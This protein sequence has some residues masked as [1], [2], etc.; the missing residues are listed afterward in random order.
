MVELN[1]NWGILKQEETFDNYC[2]L[3][4]SLGAGRATRKTFDLPKKLLIPHPKYY[5]CKHSTC[6]L[7]TRVTLL[8]ENYARMTEIEEYEQI[9]KTYKYFAAKLTKFDSV[10]YVPW[11]NDRETQT[12]GGIVVSSSESDRDAENED[13]VAPLDEDA[14]NSGTLY[15][16]HLL[17]NRLTSLSSVWRYALYPND[18]GRLRFQSESSPTFP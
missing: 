16:V 2:P 10:P 11:K 17:S 1:Q 18:D 14:L 15:D 13:E 9:D 12:E 3:V 6:F 7:K 5:S 4:S 8:L